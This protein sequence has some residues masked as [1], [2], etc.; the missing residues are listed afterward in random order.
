MRGR[1]NSSAGAALAGGGCV[2][3]ISIWVICTAVFY[4]AC[5]KVAEY[6]GYPGWLGVGLALIVSGFFTALRGA[7]N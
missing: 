1:K 5:Y 4:F 2:A 7:S 6:F 3:V